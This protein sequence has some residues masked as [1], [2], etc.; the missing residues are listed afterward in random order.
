M[1]N[2]L[3]RFIEVRKLGKE[4]ILEQNLQRTSGNDH[5]HM[6]MVHQILALGV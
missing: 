6:R 2:E 1:K 4:F 5:M 3:P